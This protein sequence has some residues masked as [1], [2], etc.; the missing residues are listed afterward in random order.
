MNQAEREALH[1]KASDAEE[2]LVVDETDHVI[3]TTSRA[4]LRT[5]HLIG[6]GT[7]IFLLNGK[8]ELCVH[9]RTLSKA[10]YPGF[11]DVCAGGMVGAF[12]TY[13]QSAERE[14]AEELGITDAPL[15]FHGTLRFES[16]DNNLWCGVF[17]AVSDQALSPQPE[18]VLQAKFIALHELSLWLSQ[19]KV[20]PDSLKAMALV[21]QL[22][23][24]L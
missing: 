23:N 18:E 15:T 11:W 13:A 7:F 2:V 14:L 19:N 17:S 12:E 1:R 6:R 16:V 9:Q 3:G 4:R 24:Y 8:G 10:L 20:C 22:A 5:E 21:P